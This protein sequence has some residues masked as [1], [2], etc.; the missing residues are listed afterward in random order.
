MKGWI[1][2]LCC[3]LVLL[4]CSCGSQKKTEKSGVDLPQILEKKELVVLTVNSSVSYFNY[5]GE[6]MGF[7]HA[8]ERNGACRAA[9][10]NHH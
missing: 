1:T 4:S 8:P 7:L 2:G 3:V 5:R 10:G 6:P 9:K